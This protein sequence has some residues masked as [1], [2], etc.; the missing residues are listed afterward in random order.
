MP[1]N[2]ALSFKPDNNFLKRYSSLFT[3]GIICVFLNFYQLFLDQLKMILKS[4]NII[5]F[6]FLDDFLDMVIEVKQIL[7]E[8]VIGFLYDG[9]VSLVVVRFE[10]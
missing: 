1:K 9:I 5:G 3:V 8:L 4:S 2:G 6:S 10:V 7:L